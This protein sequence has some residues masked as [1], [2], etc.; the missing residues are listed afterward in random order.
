MEGIKIHLKGVKQ[1][2]E[3]KFLQIFLKE[4]YCFRGIK[5]LM[6]YLLVEEIHLYRCFKLT[7]M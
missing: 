6:E 1:K 4:Y 7:L 5:F 3:K 2:F